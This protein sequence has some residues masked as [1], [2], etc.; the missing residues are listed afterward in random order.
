MDVRTA[1]VQL[2]TFWTCESG[3]ARGIP[4]ASVLALPDAPSFRRTPVRAG[5]FTSCTREQR[6]SP[7][8]RLRGE[9][10]AGA[11]QHQ[12]RAAIAGTNGVP[13][14][15]GKYWIRTTC[16]SGLSAREQ[17]RAGF[18]RSPR[19]A[20]TMRVVHRQRRR[21]S[22]SQRWGNL[23]EGEKTTPVEAHRSCLSRVVA[24]GL[25]QPLDLDG[26]CIVVCS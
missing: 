19:T 15:T 5:L 20:Q 4:E 2:H 8:D 25:F 6:R 13:R 21:Q 9:P 18:T 1:G 17:D 24:A 14:R 12:V 7:P 10:G 16:G 22:V 23:S 11:S 3:P 26:A